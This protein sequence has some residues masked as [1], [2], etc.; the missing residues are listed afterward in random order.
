MSTSNSMGKIIHQKSLS[1]NPKDIIDPDLSRILQKE[2]IK[3]K[4]FKFSNLQKGLQDIEKTNKILLQNALQKERKVLRNQNIRIS[5]QTLPTY[6]QNPEI[7]VKNLL[8]SEGQEKSKVPINRS[9]TIDNEIER[10]SL[11]CQ[12]DSFYKT[13]ETKFSNH[14]LNSKLL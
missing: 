12:N 5:L 3:P 6:D 4:S 8:S 14:L 1:E 10:N 9:Q 7:I 13:K 2:T 11:D